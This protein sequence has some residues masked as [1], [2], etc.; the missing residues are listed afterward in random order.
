[1]NK[2][3]LNNAEMENTMK[4]IDL[5]G[6]EFEK[7]TGQDKLLETI[8]TSA[9]G[10]SIVKLFVNP[11]VSQIGGYL[12]N[13]R[14]STALIP[15]FIKNNEIDMNHYE[16]K[17]Y[18]SYNEFFTRRIREGL[19]PIQGD[20]SELISPSDGKV[21]AYRIS[22]DLTVKVKNTY[23]TIESLLRNKDLASRYEN[24]YCVII[25]LTVDDYHRYCYVAD[26]KK[27]NNVRVPGALH[28]V[29]PI[30]NDFVPIYKENTR[31]Y[32]LIRSSEFGDIIQMEVGALFVGKIRN[33]HDKKIIH[34]G[35]EKGLFEF[36]G[37]SIILLLDSE[38]VGINM[39]LI[40]NT[41]NGYETI[42]KMGQSIGNKKNKNSEN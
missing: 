3:I 24:G 26:G 18:T 19:R 23:Y 36:G 40:D 25:R 4:Y 14:L 8:Y 33:H 12:L 30:A 16:E 20:S 21:S 28:T 9:L 17:Y 42:I 32:C 31:E 22:K 41:E 6:N 13:T 10:R 34:R 37:S 39:K 1:M 38:R 35:E 7:N 5:E 2:K 11:I 15:S 27:S 29:N